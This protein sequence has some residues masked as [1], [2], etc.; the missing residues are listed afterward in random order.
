MTE[1][2]QEKA[3]TLLITRESDESVQFPLA[4][5]MWINHDANHFYIRFFQVVPP[6]VRKDGD[7][8]ESVKAKLVTT[9][10]IPAARMP[11]IIRALTDNARNYERTTGVS[12]DW[13]EAEEEE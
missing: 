5:N 2:R 12:L 8:P 9:L 7:I 6:L 11:S 10:A 4:Q 1:E 3:V 13:G